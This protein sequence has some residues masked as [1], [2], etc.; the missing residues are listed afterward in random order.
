M[1]DEWNVMEG[2]DVALSV[3]AT[4][5]AGLGLYLITTQEPSGAKQL[6]S[7]DLGETIILKQ[8]PNVWV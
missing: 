6:T 5:I 8:Y 1:L 7:V 2:K 3:V 4:I